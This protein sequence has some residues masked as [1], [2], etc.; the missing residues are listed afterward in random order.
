MCGIAGVVSFL[1][2]SVNV[3]A[4]KLMLDSL[5]HRGPDGAGY[6]FFHTGAKHNLNISFFLSLV[7]SKFKDKNPL[8]PVFGD[9]DVSNEL[10]EHDWD[11]FIGHR[12][13]AIIDLT[14][15]A[16]QPM[17]D[18]TKNIWISFN[19]E[20]Y[21]F[22]E[23]K[24]SLRDYGHKF[25]SNSD[26]EVILY[27]YIQY[28]KKS[29]EMFNGMFSFVIFDNFEKKLYLVR[30]RYGTKP[31]YYTYYN[32]FFVFAS[33]VKA[34]L[35]YLDFLKYSRDIDYLGLF[36]YFTFQNFFSNRTLYKD[37]YLIPAGS[38]IEI[39]LLEKGFKLENYWDFNFNSFSYFEDYK[40]CE[41]NVYE[42]FVNAVKNQLISDVEI[43][44]YLSGGD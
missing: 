36:E 33:E 14:Y 41:E 26:T 28:K 3:S 11:L 20:I 12:R 7:D 25:K 38:Y 22:K 31:L 29:F 17:S 6:L 18:L 13:L 39:D 2:P 35:F 40:K 1:Y 10:F 32:G 27:S 34:I 16:H 4:C 19:G 9:P 30:D 23:L 43:G 42:L 44:S 21:N 37:I 24:S 8:L 5:E 15:K